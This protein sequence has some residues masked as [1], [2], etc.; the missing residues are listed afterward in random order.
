MLHKLPKDILIKLISHVEDD[1]KQKY[2]NVSK[3][4]EMLIELLGQR[5]Q[6]RMCNQPN[7]KEYCYIYSTSCGCDCEGD[8]DYIGTSESTESD[9]LSMILLNDW[10]N[11]YNTGSNE[12]FEQ[13]G[14]ACNTCE[15]WYCTKHWIDNVIQLEAYKNETVTFCKECKLGEE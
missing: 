2:T 3:S 7:C 11:D 14:I 9:E 5:L 15:V 12:H 8:R 13:Y 10:G 4:L 6:K 1:Y